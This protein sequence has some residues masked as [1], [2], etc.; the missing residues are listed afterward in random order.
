[1]L[2]LIPLA[3]LILAS[4]QSKAADSY[5]QSF[6][7]TPEFLA[8]QP[9]PTFAP[10]ETWA[11]VFDVIRN[12]GTVVTLSSDKEWE[13]LKPAST[14]KLFTGWWAFQ[15]QFRTDAYLSKM[16]H[17]S[18][19][20]MAQ[21]TL[22]GMGGL[23]AM[24]E[25]Y[26]ETEVPLDPANFI[27]V[28]GSG[29]SYD[30]RMTC[31]IQIKLLKLMRAHPNYNRFKKFLAQPKQVGTLKDRLSLYSGKLFAKTGTLNKTASL[32]GFLE[33]TKGTMVFCVMSDY[34][35]RSLVSARKR[36]D[37][38]VKVNYNLIR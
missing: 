34:L 24:E 32:S 3:F 10:R 1:M 9:G 33:S 19:N 15:K 4:V 31:E 28:D 5:A 16:L 29:L 25:Y 12:D 13:M 30:N 22:E 18:V 37:H 14:L 21:E 35:E 23:V 38:M 20:L 2:R 7:D 36:I 11:Y 26:A 6:E 8:P 17:E 27:A